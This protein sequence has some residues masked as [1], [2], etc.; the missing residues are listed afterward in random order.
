M[1]GLRGKGWE[2]PTIDIPFAVSAAAEPK[3]LVPLAGIA[4]SGIKTYSLFIIMQ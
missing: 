4:S 1:G 2:H 3:T